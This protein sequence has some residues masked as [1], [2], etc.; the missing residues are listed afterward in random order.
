[1]PVSIGSDCKNIRFL[2]VHC[3][4]DDD[5]RDATGRDQRFGSG[6]RRCETSEVAHI[7]TPIA[8]FGAIIEQRAPQ[9][10]ADE[11]TRQRIAKLDD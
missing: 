2:V 7:S 11:R 5:A 10:F 8:V 4:G 3:Y 1:M 9:H 6:A